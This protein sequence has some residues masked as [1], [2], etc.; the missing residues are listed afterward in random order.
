[1]KMHFAVVVDP[2]AATAKVRVEYS[3][4]RVPDPRTTR[5]PLGGL[6]RAV[7]LTSPASGITAASVKERKLR[8][9]A[10]IEVNFMIAK[11]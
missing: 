7:L 3:P 10:A 9:A 4:E 8:A 11:A 5:Q 1:M 6:E 2:K